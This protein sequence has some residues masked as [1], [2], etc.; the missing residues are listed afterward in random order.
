[1]SFE[2]LG[3]A[4]PYEGSAWH[5]AEYR[6]RPSDAFVRLLVSHLAWTNDD[7]ILDLGSGPG[8]IALEVAPYVGEVLAVDIEQ[9]MVDEGRR[10]ADGCGIVNARF[11]RGSSDDVVSMAADIGVVRAVTIGS[12][13]HWM[14]DQDAVLRALAP[15]IDPIGGAVLLV[16]FHVDGPDVTVAGRDGRP[17]QER[18]PWSRAR[19]LLDSYL[20][21]VPEG[22]HP[23]GRHDPFPDILDRSPFSR[24]ELLR[25][26]YDELQTP[27]VD[28]A[29]GTLYSLSNVLGRLGAKRAEYEAEVHEALDDAPTEAV[30]VRVTES[31][32]IATRSP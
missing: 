30:T 13:F 23:R 2:G 12:A 31:A 17:W 20:I 25:Y 16:G 15:L 11:L 18:Q 19:E 27:S 32:L 8:Q 9:D 24:L 21:D 28:A 3:G 4:R 7:R 10:R 5:Y 26:E 22:H 1:M 29:I 6:P 14:T